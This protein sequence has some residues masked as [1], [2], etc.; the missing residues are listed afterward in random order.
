M[1]VE[2]QVSTDESQSSRYCI[3]GVL[4]T[5]AP[6]NYNERTNYPFSPTLLPSY[7]NIFPPDYTISNMNRVTE[8]IHTSTIQNR[9]TLARRNGKNGSGLTRCNV[10][11]IS[12]HGA[13]NDDFT[14]TEHELYTVTS[15]HCQLDNLSDS[16]S[17]PSANT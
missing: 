17:E 1:M 12:N 9:L 14:N 7:E 6:P 2:R 3:N 10:L 15:Y 16:D 5:E 4:L 8:Q 13:C 11:V